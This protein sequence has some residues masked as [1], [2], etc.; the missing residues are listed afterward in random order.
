MSY[1]DSFKFMNEI[2][3]AMLD[4]EDKLARTTGTS[5]VNESSHPACSLF[6]FMYANLYNPAQQDKY[7]QIIGN[8]IREQLMKRIRTA[9]MRVVAMVGKKFVDQITENLIDVISS[10]D[11][12]KPSA[13]RKRLTVYFRNRSSVWFCAM[14]S[15]IYQSDA[16]DYAYSHRDV[17]PKSELTAQKIS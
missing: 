9:Q 16:I 17:K 2:I 15:V 13:S 10:N 4:D 6:T 7:D 12:D 14:A 8:P 11:P 3:R 1:E 5:S